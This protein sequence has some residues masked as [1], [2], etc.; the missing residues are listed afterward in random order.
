MRRPILV[1][2]FLLL[3]SCVLGATVF[4][5]QV[6]SAGGRR[7]HA[8]ARRATPSP[9][10]VV[11]TDG[12]GVSTGNTVKIDPANNAISGTVGLSASANMVTV[13]NTPSVK[14]DPSG[15]TVTVGNQDSNGNVKVHE[16][17]TANVNVT[18]S[19][20]PVAPPNPVTG[21]GGTEFVGFGGT[22]A[23]S[24]TATFFSIHLDAGIGAVL[25][26]DGGNL[27]GGFLGPNNGGVSDINTPL[28]R[29]VSFD[30]IKCP[31]ISGVCTV[32]WFGN[33]P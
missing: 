18:N 33:S 26:E 23:I 13:G 11:F 28:S 24:G 6:A 10:P 7:A 22:N 12:T 21:G 31:G 5:D 30:H 4:R 9:D 3:A 29:P 2:G 25:F 32:T 15:N 1:A 17:G 14:V 19:S 16:Q 8:A 20:L 27:V